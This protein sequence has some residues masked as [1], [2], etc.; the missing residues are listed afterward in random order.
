MTTNTAREGILASEEARGRRLPTG[1][2][3][4]GGGG[5][6]AERRLAGA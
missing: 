4:S 3:A 1:E 5:R 6:R 2:L